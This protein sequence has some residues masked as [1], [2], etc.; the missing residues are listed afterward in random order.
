[1]SQCTANESVTNDHRFMHAILTICMCG[2]L[3]SSG[4]MGFS[5]AEITLYPGCGLVDA[6][7]SIVRVSL[8]L[9][10]LPRCLCFDCVYCTHVLPYQNACKHWAASG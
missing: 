2:H 7:P 1:M 4:F 6:V 8:Y 3:L 9:H 10:V 5:L